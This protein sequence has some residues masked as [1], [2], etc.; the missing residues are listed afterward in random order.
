MAVTFASMFIR[1]P[2]PSS[3]CHSEWALNMDLS[4]IR[5]CDLFGCYINACVREY[6]SR[7]ICHVKGIMRM[8]AQPTKSSAGVSYMHNLVSVSYFEI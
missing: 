1:R 7:K 4:T 2:Q 3:I 6:D 8:Y 5:N